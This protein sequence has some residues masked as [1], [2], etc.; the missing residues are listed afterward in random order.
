VARTLPLVL[1]AVALGP[2]RTR[3]QRGVAVAGLLATWTTAYVGYR[4]AAKARTATEWE[5]LSLT[6]PEVFSRHYNERVP[7]VEEELDTWGPYHRH[8]HHMR[9]GLV[10]TMVREHLSPGD[11]ILDLGCGSALLAGRLLDVDAAYVGMD[12]GGHHIDSAKR[13]SAGWRGRLRPSFARGDA[14]GL[15]FASNA[16]D[17]VVMSEVIEHFL[18]PDLAV[19]ETARV[20]RPGGVLVVTTNNAS[21]MPLRSPLSHL[22]VWLEKALGATHPHLIS[23]RPWIWPDPI[24]RELLPEGSPPLFVPHTHHI[25]AETRRL[26]EAAGLQ[27]LG[28]STFEFPPPPS[29]TAAWLDA[30]EDGGIAI[31]DRI[32]AVARRIPLVNRMGCHLSIVA[33]KT[34]PEAASRP[35]AGLWPGPFSLRPEAA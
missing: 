1:T 20:L 35:P 14:E 6:S 9:Y 2:R 34:G 15:P 32:E 3:R 8:R 11:R 30:R 13:N 19:W 16:F 12:F 4:R 22:F 21:E 10:A 33:R 18:R 24:D 28:R 7:T 31:A 27:T 23:D 29:A 25:Q 17:L 5:L 26:L